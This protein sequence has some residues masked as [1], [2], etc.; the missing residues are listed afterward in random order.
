MADPNQ[1]VTTVATDILDAVR[2]RLEKHN[3]THDEYRAAVGWFIKLAESGEVP[4]FL[5]VFFEATVERLTYDGLPGSAGTVEGP[6]YLPGAPELTETPMVLPMRPDEPGEP[7]VFTGTVRNLDGSPLPGAL[8]DMW[9]AGNDGTYSGFVGDAPRT[10]LRGKMRTDQDGVVQVRSI[11]PAP[12]QIPH[13]GPTGEFLTMLGKHSWRPAHFHFIVSADGYEP[14][15]SQL[16]FRGGP[17]LDGDGDVVGA[18]KDPLVIDVGLSSDQDIA[19][20]Y[21][22][23]S[24]FKTS[25]YTFTLREAR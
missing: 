21:G 14:L 13:D 23:T 25:E 22:L 5:D 15:T 24:P 16:Y 11:R 10:N 3:L 1:R 4:L 2:E 17:W 6:Y 8:I 20:K 18:V 12:Y 9:Q 7:I 19:A